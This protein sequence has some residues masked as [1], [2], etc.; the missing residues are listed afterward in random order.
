MDAFL[1]AF[2]CYR[3]NCDQ[4]ILGVINIMIDSKLMTFINVAKLRSYTRAAEML[5]LTQPAVTQHI[6][7]LEEYYGVKLIKKKGRQISLTEEGGVD[8]KECRGI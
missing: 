2:N 8:I 4:D 1:K 6:K 7:Q 5:N 3:I